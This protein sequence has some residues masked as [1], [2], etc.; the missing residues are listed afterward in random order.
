MLYHYTTREAA[1]S[2]LRDG[3]IRPRAQTLYSDV[4][5]S[6]PILTTEP[7]VWLTI[8]PVIEMTVVNKFVAAKLPWATPGEIW[9]FAV[10]DG[11]GGDLGLG[12]YTELVGIDHS[13]WEWVV[14][15]GH[16]VGSNYTTWRIVRGGIPRADWLS[17]ESFGG[18]TGPAGYTWRPE[19]FIPG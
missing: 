5:A 7:I 4:L 8:N 14:K 18:P 3:M 10:A 11:Y 19:L 15:T 9:R 13:A 17:L 12:D 16:L 2:I 6:V 1:A